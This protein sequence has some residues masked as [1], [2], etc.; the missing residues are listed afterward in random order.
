MGGHQPI[1]TEPG[2]EWF[3]CISAGSFA[4]I[5]FSKMELI[6][7]SWEPVIARHVGNKCSIANHWK[8]QL[9]ASPSS[10]RPTD[11]WITSQLA[12][13]TCVPIIQ[14]SEICIFVYFSAI[15]TG[16]TAREMGGKKNLGRI[17]GSEISSVWVQDFKVI[18]ASMLYF[19]HPFLLWEM[20]TTSRSS[21]TNHL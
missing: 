4:L 5:D 6:L 3:S 10:P 2:N 13:T 12:G 18:G 17:P 15:E 11:P 9:N 1:L 8:P 14:N 16:G 20:L 21:R 7:K 19:W